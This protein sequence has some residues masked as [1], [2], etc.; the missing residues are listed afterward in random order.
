[1]EKVFGGRKIS[2]ASN[3]MAGLEAAVFHV[4]EGPFPKATRPWVPY[5]SATAPSE[6]WAWDQL[7]FQSF[8][9][10]P[11]APLSQ[12]L[13][14]INSTTGRH[15]GVEVMDGQGRQ[16]P[17][18]GPALRSP[19]ALPWHLGRGGKRSMVGTAREGIHRLTSMSR[20]AQPLGGSSL[21]QRCGPGRQSTV[22]A[23]MAQMAPGWQQGH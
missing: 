14:C 11:P 21:E 23:G 13:V 16:R 2:R 9:P 20:F 18:W 19:T 22:A 8:Q 15:G 7:P 1:M 3:L 10:P 5:A 6:P 4:Q 12:G 17:R